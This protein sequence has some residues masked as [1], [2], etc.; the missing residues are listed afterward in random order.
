M[1]TLLS[2]L[3]LWQ[4]FALL[5]LCGV[6]LASAPLALFIIESNK[7]T[8]IAQLAVRGIAPIQALL[9]T[10]TLTQQHRGLS[11]M[12]LA[13]NDGAKGAR[14]AKQDE[15]AAAFA[16]MDALVTQVGDAAIAAQWQQAKA[17]WGTVSGQVAQQ[18]VSAQESIR[19]HTD[20][21]VDLLQMNAMLVDRFGLFTNADLDTRYLI[22]S[23]LL[24]SPKLT[25]A[26]GR[27][28]AKG[29]G[30]LTAG[31]ATLEDRLAM[32][33]MM[34]KVK[35]LHGSVGVAL[36]KA[37]AVNPQFER[38]LASH[39]QGT[40]AIGHKALELAQAQIINQE[41]LSFPAAD[42]F[43]QFTAAIDAQIKLNDVALDQLQQALDARVS[44]LRTT[45]LTLIGCIVLLLLLIMLFIYFVSLSVSGPLRKAIDCARQIA[46]GDLAV[47]IESGSK[48][49]TGQLLEALKDMRDSLEGI[50][51]EVRSSTDAIA[52]ASGQIASGNLDLS[53]RTEAQASALE[54]T[55]SSMEEMTGTVKQ[56]ADNARHAQ[57]LSLSAAQIAIKGG[58][59]VSQVVETMGDINA[60]SKK[61]ADI[62]GVID[63]IAFQTNILALNAAVEAARAGEQ[64]RGFAVVATEVRN[65]A[66]RSAAAA[67]EIKGL[68]DDSVSKVDLG[69]KLVDQAGATMNEVVASVKQVTDI[70]AE[71]TAASVEQTSGI[72]QIN[73]AIM[74][75][76]DATQQNA[77]LV[78]QAAA[79]AQS[80]QEQTQTLSQ[81]VGVFKLTPGHALSV[82]RVVAS[83]PAPGAATPPQRSARPV[84]K[85]SQSRALAPAKA[86]VSSNEW[87]EF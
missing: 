36:G 42:Y 62:I 22:E 32:R 20:L 28:R 69:A 33:A 78:E 64:G 51:G 17:K 66:Q 58:A 16:A 7:T 57:Q 76:D 40:L 4:K 70:I 27:M 87:E 12:V 24:E 1:N 11:A 73:Q 35:D 67:K 71:I 37:M 65:L 84:Q 72:D 5:A 83:V 49:E 48:N 52:T 59:V 47:E 29:A 8:D 23:T 14:A 53:S 25:E 3:L 79:A 56:N 68:I 43:K 26:L 63:G 34:E 31:S 9:K 38:S 41:Q 44:A 54:E 75:M 55:A 13:G 46:L 39:A 21:I 74:Q 85:A 82:A 10:V 30:L 18:S 80:L 61:I 50:V 15:V 81:A 77:A 19:L 60:S 86:T 2:R 6:I 45:T